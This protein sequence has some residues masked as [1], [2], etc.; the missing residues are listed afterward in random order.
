MKRTVRRA[1]GRPPSVASRYAWVPEEPDELHVAAC[2][3]R[4]LSSLLNSVASFSARRRSSYIRAVIPT[5]TAEFEA[6]SAHP[7]VCSGFLR[8]DGP[9]QADPAVSREL[10]RM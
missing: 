6:I 1:A 2:V 8:P 10:T 4:R 3:F 9:S 5:D 7:V